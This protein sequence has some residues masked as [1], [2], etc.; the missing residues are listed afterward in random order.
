MISVILCFLNERRFLAETV[1][2]V[3]AQSCTE[4]ELILIDDGST[5]G[6]TELARSYAQ[7]RPQ[8]VRYIDRPGHSNIGLPASRNVGIGAAKGKYIAFLDADDI[9]TPNKLHDQWALMEAHPEAAAVHGALC[10]WRS[11]NPEST[12]GD[13]VA[14]PDVGLDSLVSPPRLLVGCYPIGSGTPPAPSDL[15][16]R[17]DA[18]ERLGRFEERFCGPYS[19]FE[20][21]GF[22]CKL[23]LHEHV[24]VSGECWTM[25]R[26]RPGSLCDTMH[27]QNRY[28]D[29][30]LFFFRFLK[31]YLEGQALTSP[32]ILGAV[33]AAEL[34]SYGRAGRVGVHL[35]RL[36]GL[37]QGARAA[38]M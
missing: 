31:E 6:S 30:L 8:K 11:W 24:Y 3:F 23:Y 9:W 34:R 22:L 33:D 32:E 26:E 2:S 29:Q 17:K 19:G 38:R 20:D 15:M 7:E 14:L 12:G 5:D 28:R 4:W 18:L 25:Y 27:S 35:L 21:Q 37:S 16:V 1:A 13:Q 36:L 10:Y